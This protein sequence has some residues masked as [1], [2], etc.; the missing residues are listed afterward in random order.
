MIEPVNKWRVPFRRSRFGGWLVLFLATAVLGIYTAYDFTQALGKFWVLLG[1][2]AVYWAIVS[3]PRRSTFLLAGATGPIGALLAVYFVLSNDWR[4]WRADIGFLNRLGRSWMAIRPSFSFLPVVHPNTLAGMMALLLPFTLAFAI[5]AW[6]RRKTGWF[7]FALVC[8]STTAGGLVFTSS[9]GAWLALAVGLGIWLFWWVSRRIGSQR[10]ALPKLLAL[11]VLPGGLALAGWLLTSTRL[12]F[13]LLTRWDLVRQTFFLRQDF[14]FTG[15]GLATFPALYSQY[16]RVIPNYFVAYSNLY[17]DI[18]LELGFL[19]LVSLLAILGVS[20]WRLLGPMRWG[21]RPL[22]W[23]QIGLFEWAAFVS[24]MVMCLHGLTDDALFGTQA[25]PLLFFAPAMVTLVT[26]QPRRAV[27]LLPLRRWG[28]GLGGTAVL[29]GIL[30]FSFRPAIMAQWQA[31][32]AALAL[33]REELVGWPTDQWDRGECLECY[34]PAKAAFGQALALN[35]QNRTA[36][37]RLGLL[38]MLERDYD[39]AVAHLEA[40]LARSPQHRGI[41]KSLGYS[42]VWQG[43]LEKAANLL[44]NIP[45]AQ[46]EMTVYTSWWQDQGRPDLASQ[47][48]EMSDILADIQRQRRFR[49]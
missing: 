12:R 1:A 18:W 23:R 47:A 17:L 22:W 26:R 7:W 3:L 40:A 33:A 42:Y 46:V 30:F 19:A 48:S 14:A 8:L 49:E 37:Y 13:D 6:R 11:V 28:M 27:A 21:K 39:T 45:E 15:S 38:A 32:L 10:P 25:S 29:L 36:N 9:L 44:A 34:A 24:L 43:E 35:P 31:N 20:F 5:F 41:V 2:T 4:L 16:V